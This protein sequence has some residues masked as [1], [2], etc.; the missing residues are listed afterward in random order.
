MA[1][2]YRLTL[3][4]EIEDAWYLSEIA[5]E[6]GKK[7]SEAYFNQ[8]KY[9]DHL[10][11]LTVLPNV[12]GK[13]VDFR[14]T[15]FGV[16]IVS[17]GLAETVE[18]LD[19]R[20]IQRIPVTVAPS[21][22]GYEILNILAILDCVDHEQTTIEYYTEKEAPPRLTGRV[23]L[24]QNIVLKPDKIE[25]H[26][27]FRLAEKWVVIVVSEALKKALEEKKFTGMKFIHL[28]ELYS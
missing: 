3:E 24:M 18:K 4:V 15:S 2:Y 7:V 8:G 13:P 26:H 27:I 17:S 6:N 19:L 23:K 11:K 10:T 20:A 28:N 22:T 16:P 1:N 21:I 5:N 25:G 12:S 9:F 14:E